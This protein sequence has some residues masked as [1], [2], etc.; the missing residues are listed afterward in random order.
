MHSTAISSARW[1]TLNRGQAFAIHLLLSLLA[2]STLVFAMLVWWFPGELFLLDGGW[3]GLKLVAMI[4]LVLGPALTLLLYRPGKPGLLLDLTLIAAIQVTAL[5]Y[6]FVTTWQQRTV[7]VVYAENRFT[8]LSD[9]ALQA[10]NS[11]LRA[12]DIAPRPLPD[13]P[14]RGPAL[15]YTPPPNNDDFGQYLADL[16]NGLPEPHERSDLFKPVSSAAKELHRRA[17]KDE[18]LEQTGEL[19]LITK[20][21]EEQDLDRDA[22]DLHR[23]RSRYSSGIA[24]FDPVR[25]TIIDFVAIDPAAS[26]APTESNDDPP[27]TSA[28][29]EE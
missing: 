24:L 14:D 4:D 26:K 16:M 29:S 3:Q 22:V 23:F 27:V 10:A 20:A 12:R 28:E 8:T 2:V 11:D 7:A 13:S 21:L 17:L 19:A 6:G 15:L 9:D 1:S 25:H 18:V 5:A